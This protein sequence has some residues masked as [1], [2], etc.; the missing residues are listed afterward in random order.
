MSRAVE[1]NREEYPVSKP[2]CGAYRAVYV[3]TSVVV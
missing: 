2:V 3:K 1:K